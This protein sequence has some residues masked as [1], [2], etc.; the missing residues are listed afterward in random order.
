MSII[1][2]QPQQDFFA[3]HIKAGTLSHAYIFSGVRG[4]GKRTVAD[5]V[6]ATALGHPADQLH[7]HP[8]LHVVE[9]G[10]NE[11]TGKTKK[12][13]DVEQ[14]RALRSHMS[15]RSHTGGLV[16]GLVDGA[17]VMNQNAANALLK[18][19]EEPGKDSLLILITEDTAALPMTIRSR[20]QE[21]PFHPVSRDE[22]ADAL[23]ARGMSADASQVSARQSLG[24]PGWAFSWYTTDEAPEGTVPLASLLGVPLYEKQSKIDHLFGKK[25]DHIAQREMLRD[26]LE[27][28]QVSLRD[29]LLIQSGYEQVASDHTPLSITRSQAV[30]TLER[31]SVARRELRQNIHPRL[32]FDT[33]FLSLP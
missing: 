12:N 30:E 26:V 16:I 11:K 1:G 17:D 27:S 2:H 19:L 24:R 18:V 31:I 15:K 14:V 23:V 25:V 32:I 33:I 21:I 10:T 4:V 28:W 7:L 22:V 13:I 29:Q 9:R 8:D 5:W 20:S 3:R 6:L